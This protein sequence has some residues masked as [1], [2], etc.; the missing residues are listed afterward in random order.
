MSAWS[1]P[2]SVDATVTAPPV[3][4][5]APTNFSVSKSGGTVTLSARAPTTG[6]FATLKFKRSGGPYSSAVDVQTFTPSLGQTVT[7]ADTPGA[8]TW[9]YWAV[10]FADDGTP[11]TPVGPQTI[12]VP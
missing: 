12:T 5:P 1:L 4:T 3:V 6:G 2:A 10:C 7:Y 11:S 9:N 8:N